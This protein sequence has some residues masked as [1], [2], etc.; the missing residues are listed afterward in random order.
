MCTHARSLCQIS[1]QHDG[2][3][4]YQYSRSSDRL[5][6]LGS[7]LCGLAAASRS[8]S[9]GRKACGPQPLAGAPR[10]VHGHTWHR[11]RGGGSTRAMG[12]LGSLVGA[13]SPLDP[14]VRLAA[15]SFDPLQA[16]SRH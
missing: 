14:S 13:E 15:A 12:W 8:P 1:T 10:L 9:D 7:I 2:I 6:P 11:N 5:G 16:P 4:H 3:H